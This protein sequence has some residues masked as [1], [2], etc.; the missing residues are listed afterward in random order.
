MN[1]IKLDEVL[2]FNQFVSH[3]LPKQLLRLMKRMDSRKHEIS[4]T[5][6]NTNPDISNE[7]TFHNKDLL[8]PLYDRINKEKL[9]ID[10]SSLIC[11]RITNDFKPRGFHT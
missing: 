5:T 6:L 11:F 9:P 1:S 2:G 10:Y 7:L 4:Q 3:V 8:S